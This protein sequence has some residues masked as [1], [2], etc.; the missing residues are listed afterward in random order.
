MKF[1]GLFSTEISEFGTYDV[2]DGKTSGVVH[3]PKLWIGS[4]VIVLFL[5]SEGGKNAEDS[6]NSA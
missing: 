6:D 3:V 5:S 1:E 4:K 2:R